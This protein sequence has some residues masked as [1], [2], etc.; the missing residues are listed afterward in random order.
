MRMRL[1]FQ[2]LQTYWAPVR[3]CAFLPNFAFHR[4]E[5]RTRTPLILVRIQVPQPYNL[6]I[7]LRCVSFHLR[8]N[9]S[10]MSA[11]YS[12][13]ITMVRFQRRNTAA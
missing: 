3:R 5:Q 7:L 10:D 4:V 2:A 13:S 11:V 9:S 6:L 1:S 12:P 8:R